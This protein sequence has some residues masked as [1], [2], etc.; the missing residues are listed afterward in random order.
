MLFEKAYTSKNRI[1]LPMVLLCYITTVIVLFY[2]SVLCFFVKLGFLCCQCRDNC[3][4]Y[5]GRGGLLE[6][7]RLGVWLEL[8]SATS[9][10]SCDLE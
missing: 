2:S 7:G 8:H 3:S 4:I 6:G 10:T 5:W 1:K 9:F